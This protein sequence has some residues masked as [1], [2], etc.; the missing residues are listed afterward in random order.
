MMR[1]VIIIILF[2]S[3][4][5]FVFAEKKLLGERTV[6]FK[7]EKDTIDVTYKE[8]VFTG[9][10]FKVSGNDVR[11]YD[12]TVTYGNKSKDDIPVK[13]VFKEGDRSRL[14]DLRGNKRIISHIT[15][16]YK[17]A[18]EKKEGKAT[19]KVFGIRA[20]DM[21]KLGTRSVAFAGDIDT[22]RVTILKG[23]FTGLIFKVE[24]NDIKISKCT[25]TY[26]NG[27]VDN[28]P[29]DW[30]F[31]EG[32]RSRLIDLEGNKR[33]IKKITFIYKTT[34][35]LKDGRAQVTVYGVR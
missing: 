9:L 20:D 24:K 7:A 4:T 23:F 34:G 19:I 6:N 35:K 33:L 32:D 18:G 11:V 17:T 29:V 25:V 31:E 13:W 8:G 16:F 3:M 22:I 10:I 5:C 2:L 27:D 28:I 1:K 26:G 14:I 21:E 30:K 12:L 15:F